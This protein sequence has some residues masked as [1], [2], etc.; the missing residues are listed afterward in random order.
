MRGRLPR[1]AAG[2]EAWAEACRLLD[3]PAPSPLAPAARTAS[4]RTA[5]A[6]TPASAP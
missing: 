3:G 4:G 2:R 1:D 6:A 5:E